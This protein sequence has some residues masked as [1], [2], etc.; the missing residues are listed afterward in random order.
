MSGSGPD[1]GP[2]GPGPDFGQS[3]S[4]CHGEEAMDGDNVIH[5]KREV[6]KTK[7]HR[8]SS[9]PFILIWHCHIGDIVL[10]VVII[11]YTCRQTESN[12]LVEKKKK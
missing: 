4:K 2:G 11:P 6:K 10:L 3:N 7:T 5:K 12:H 9:P 1:L 8:I